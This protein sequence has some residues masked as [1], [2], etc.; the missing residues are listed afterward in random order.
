MS[1]LMW[2]DGSF[3]LVQLLI[4]NKRPP[5]Y[6]PLFCATSIIIVIKKIVLIP[7]DYSFD[8]LSHFLR[9]T[10]SLMRKKAVKLVHS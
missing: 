9:K 4:I 1:P 8:I 3:F 6:H 7:F 10:I 2:P 5:N